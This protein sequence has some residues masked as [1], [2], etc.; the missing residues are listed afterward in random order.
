MAA[1]R[2][3]AGARRDR[4]DGDPRP[5]GGRARPT[6]SCTS[7]RGWRP[8]GAD[9]C[10]GPVSATSSL[11]VIPVP[12]PGA[13]DVVVGT[14]GRDE[15]AVFT[16]TD[17]GSI[18][19]DRP[20]RR[21][22]STGSPTPAAARSA[23]RSTPTA[24]C[25]SAT[26][27]AGCCAIDPATGGVEPARSTGSHGRPMVFCNN[28][29]VAADGD[30]WFSDSS[31]P[32][33]HRAVEGRLRPGHPHR[34]AAPARDPTATVEVVL[35]G[36]AFANGVALRRRR[37][38]RR[39]RRDGRAHRR[40]PLADRAAGRAARLPRRRPARLPRQ[41]R[42]RQRR[43]DLGDDRL[44]RATRWSSGSSTG[45]RGCAA[46]GHPDPR[47]RSSPS[48]SGPCA[49]RRT[50]TTGRLVHDLDVRRRAATTWSPACASTT[51][52]SGWAACEEP[53]VAVLNL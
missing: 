22:A 7:T 26:P 45:R 41:H 44:A 9:W 49:C 32:L 4:R 50:T 24:G 37:V 46:S 13:E 53:A 48:R 8:G 39:G 35:D 21:A 30:V 12:G 38:L 14:H 33:R 5:R 10:D 36:L 11:S 15:G 16:G 20:R 25:W 42:A 6:A 17:D 47:A 40:T 1:L 2:A 28:A 3:E 27:T 52:G 18:F 29:A 19:A 31:H 34:P 43:A 23:S 51:A